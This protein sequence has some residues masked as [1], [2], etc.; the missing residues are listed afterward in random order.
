SLPDAD[1]AFDATGYRR[2][3]ITPLGSTTAW[4][5][6]LDESLAGQAIVIGAGLSGV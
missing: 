4:P 6:V 3:T 5:V 2:G 1:T